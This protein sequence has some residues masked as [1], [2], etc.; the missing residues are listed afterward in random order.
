VVTVPGD[1]RVRRFPPT[2]GRERLGW[3]VV[4]L[5]PYNPEAMPRI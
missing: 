3:L 1:V 4:V 2:D 5:R